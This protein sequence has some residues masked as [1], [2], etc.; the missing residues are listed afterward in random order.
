[1]AAVVRVGANE[2]NGCVVPDTLVFVSIARSRRLIRFFRVAV[3]S[4]W[5]CCVCAMRSRPSIERARE[6][7]CVRV[8]VARRMTTTT[9]TT[10]KKKKNSR[11]KHGDI[12]ENV[13]HEFCWCR[14][15]V[16]LSFAVVVVSV[17]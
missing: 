12:A 1:M 6:T 16:A 8:A 11:V 15:R 14:L 4:N 2:A 13:Q 9:T 7:V 5:R 17:N 3:D 10:W